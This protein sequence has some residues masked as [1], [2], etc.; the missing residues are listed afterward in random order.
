MIIY[1]LSLMKPS[2]LKDLK[3]RVLISLRR[4]LINASVY[5]NIRLHLVI[6]WW[7]VIGSDH[8]HHHYHHRHKC[9]SV[10]QS[11]KKKVFML[12]HLDL[13]ISKWLFL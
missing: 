2:D 3:D 8:H 12:K 5:R 13:L 9:S 4:N 7:Q 11:K 10:L 6:I 1:Y